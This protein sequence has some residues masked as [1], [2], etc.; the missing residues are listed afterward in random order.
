MSQRVVR[1]Q[2]FDDPALSAHFRLL[3]ALTAGRDTGNR[4]FEKTAAVQHL[5]LAVDACLATGAQAVPLAVTDLTAGELADVTAA[6]KELDGVPHVSVTPWPDRPSGRAYYDGFCFK[7]H[8]TYEDGA[9]EVG[10]GGLGDWT[11]LLLANRKERLFTNGLAL[12]RMSDRKA[13]LNDEL[14]PA[15]FGPGR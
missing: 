13:R 6:T 9:L 1:A 15:R 7:V 3:G 2:R 10:D 4:A 5:R 14:S 8:A 12:E 11:Q